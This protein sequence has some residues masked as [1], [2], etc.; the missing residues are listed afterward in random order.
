MKTERPSEIQTA[1]SLFK[2][3]KILKLFK[4]QPHLLLKLFTF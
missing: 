1:F 3:I 4:I 2:M